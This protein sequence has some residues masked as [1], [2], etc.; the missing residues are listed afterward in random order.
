LLPDASWKKR[1]CRLSAISFTDQRYCR[2]GQ[3]KSGAQLNTRFSK[4]AVSGL[5][6]YGGPQ[7]AKPTGEAMADILASFKERRA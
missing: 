2:D 1:G 3:Q 4:S 5:L 6:H 7:G